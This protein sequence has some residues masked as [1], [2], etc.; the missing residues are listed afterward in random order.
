MASTF[1]EILAKSRELHAQGDIEGAKR[2]AKIAIQRRDQTAQQ[3]RPSVPDEV[4]ARWAA[5]RAGTLEASPESLA[6]HQAASAQYPADEG[7]WRRLDRNV[8]GALEAINRPLHR[9]NRSFTNGY[10]LGLVDEIE[11]A[12]VAAMTDKS[13]GEAVEAA[14]TQ[15]SA[16]AAEMPVISA[17]GNI[18]GS[19]AT[20]GN[21]ARGLGMQPATKLGGQ[22][23][24]GAGLGTLEGGIHGFNEGH[25][26]IV[27]RMSGAGAGALYGGGT[28]F[29]A[30]AVIHGARQGWDA[31]SGVGAS[32][33]TAPSQIRASRAVEEAIERS[34]RTPDEI[35]DAIAAAH[36]AGQTGY[37][38]A[39]ATGHSGQRM[40]AGATRTPGD[41]RQGIVDFLSN[42]QQGQG[43]RLGAMLDESLN[44]PRNTGGIPTIAGQRAP[45]DFTGMTA[46]QAR[47]SLT[48]QR[49]ATANRL[50]GEARDA[51]GPVDVRGALAALDDRL[52]PMAGVDIKGDGID[53][54]FS[55]I[56]RRLAAE[57][58]PEGVTSIE[59]SDFN[60][61]LGLKQD[62]QDMIGKAQRA[63]EGNRVRELTSVVKE[64][65]QALERA[66]AGYRMAN[67]E[68]A[69]SSRVI[70]QIDAGKAATGPRARTGDVQAAY[71]TM[72][73]EQQAAFRV[74]YSDPLLARIEGA[75]PGVN[76]ARALMD[77]ASQ[78]ELGMMAKDRKALED[79]LRRE[80]DMFR[81]GNAAMGGSMTADNLADS[82]DLSGVSSSILG[83]LF[84]GR[85][86]TAAG[87]AAQASLN[88]LQGRN[89]S[90]RNLIAELLTSGDVQKALAPAK[91]KAAETIQRSALGEA[92]LRAIQR[93]MT[94]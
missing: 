51:A 25:G 89:T 23:V 86:S 58:L 6:R 5:A 1:E 91:K 93:S 31:L 24:Q 26:G 56:R 22:M 20:S 71:G 18:L 94:P 54:T 75:A 50:Y 47:G 60:R 53:A 66:S 61:V 88:T 28:G 85:L 3:P 9:F 30:P 16:D 33:R 79:F 15:A 70:D 49:G 7:F 82:A 64:L 87:Q 17:A 2:L 74:G 78:A 8:G 44:A 14:R 65:D 41:G 43:R 76:K 59:L 55:Q 80:D 27:Q 81:T 37:S 34:G 69:R 77:D 13:Y 40:L 12:A 29:A 35:A 36:R 21:I 19:I 4:Q 63:G 42:R 62:V 90:T 39:D 46:E 10:T 73:P 38:I 72:T 57:D 52:G 32:M 92:F 45:T 48:A 68:F 67:D 11:G 83:N 84:A